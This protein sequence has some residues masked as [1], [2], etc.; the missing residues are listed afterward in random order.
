[1]TSRGLQRLLDR[2]RE[3]DILLWVEKGGKAKFKTDGPFTI[4]QLEIL[5]SLVKHY[6][7]IYPLIIENPRRRII[8]KS[9]NTV[10][11]LNK[12]YSFWG[13]KGEI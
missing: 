13:L 1:M 9:Q 10:Q 5:N 3:A 11:E 2:A 12:I 8:G 6:R 4:N 7:Q